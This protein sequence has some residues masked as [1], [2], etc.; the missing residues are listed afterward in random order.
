MANMV[1][2]VT[3]FDSQSQSWEEYCEI[4]QHFFEANEITEAVKQ[5]AI[6]LS[7][8]GSQTYSLL[9]N[10]LI[11]VKPGTKT[12]GEL[13]ELLKEHFNPK[14]SEIVQRF[15]FN[16]RSREEGETVLEYVAVL[17]KLAHD[18][19]YGEKLTEMLRDRL[20]CGINDDRIQ[21]RLLAE[22]DL[23]FEKAL[24]VAQAMETANKDVRDL[25]AKRSETSMSM[26]VHKTSVKQDESQSR[27]CYRCGSLQ[28]LANECRFVSEKCHQCGKQGH[29]MKVCKSKSSSRDTN[30][31]GGERRKRV[32]TRGG[33]RSYYVGRDEKSASDEEGIFTV[34]S[35]KETEIPKVAPLT[36]TLAV[37]ESIIPFEVDTGCGVTVMNGSN[38]SKLWTKHKIPELKTCA[39]LHKAP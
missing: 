18:C 32:V 20:V 10:L 31:Q 14:P 29:I 21:R 23:T 4:L 16:S 19:N 26:R 24:K 27:A 30:F 33:Q 38:F 9:R 7:T 6:L 35:L 2:T 3:P 17:R 15:K 28:H 11:P 1:G 34:H 37:N 8:V 39:R 36:I 13:V 25:Q 22:A 12:F 5:K